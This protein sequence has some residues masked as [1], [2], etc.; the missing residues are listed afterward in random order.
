MTKFLDR[1]CRIHFS[2]AQ[3]FMTRARHGRRAALDALATQRSAQMGSL[4]RGHSRQ[5]VNL[6]V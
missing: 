6:F 4:V 1:D 3:G 2:P 5:S